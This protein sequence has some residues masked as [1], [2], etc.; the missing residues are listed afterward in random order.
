MLAWNLRAM[1]VTATR[2]CPNTS[3][4]SALEADDTSCAFIQRPHTA[5]LAVHPQP[6]VQPAPLTYSFSL[7]RARERA[8]SPVP[9]RARAHAPR[10]RG[11]HETV[12][13]AALLM[14][15]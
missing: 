1:H 15:T 6:R 3:P 8:V 11:S 13:G 7:H 14:C 4:A 12:K 9:P 2:C 5:S 10:S